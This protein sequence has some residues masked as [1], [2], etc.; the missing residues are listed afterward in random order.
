MD[1]KQHRIC[2]VE[3]AK[4]LD[5]G[6]RVWLQN[7]RKILKP[8][9]REG[10]T[11]LDIGCGPG[12]FTIPLARLVGSK[13]KVI[14][15]DLQEEMLAMVRKK[16]EG[17]ELERIVTLRQ[18]SKDRIGVTEKCDF[19]LIFYMLHEVPDQTAFLKELYTILKPGGKAL[20]VEP[21]SRVSGKEM[22]G[23]IQIMERTGF[24]VTGKPWILL[25]RAVVIERI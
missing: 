18:C 6:I 15:A 13:G 17:T 10:M 22:A 8:Y 2:P 25:S 14:A 19:V 23:S 12:F 24:R 5:S 16:I 4:V 1:H 20:I 11:A 3:H 21:K 9:I 7:P